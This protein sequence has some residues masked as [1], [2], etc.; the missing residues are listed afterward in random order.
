[1]KAI[2]EAKQEYSR[3]LAERQVSAC[4]T[5]PGRSSVTI[6]EVLLAF[7]QWAGT[8]YRTPTGEPT[9]EIGELRRSVR[10]GN[11]R[12]S[13]KN[14]LEGFW[15]EPRPQGSGSRYPLPCGRGSFRLPASLAFF[16]LAL[17]VTP[18]RRSSAHVPSQRSVST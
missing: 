10:F 6:N 9:T 2:P 7:M 18:Q 4:L 1:M 15:N 17:T 5:T 12:A 16:P 13:G 3:L 8:H 14:C 11:F